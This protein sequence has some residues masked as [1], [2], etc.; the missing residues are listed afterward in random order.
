MLEQ[1]HAEDG[2]PDD[3][4]AARS[5]PIAPL[6][7]ALEDTLVPF[8]AGQV[9]GSYR[10][11]R[12][13][14]VGGMS[15]VYLAERTDLPDQKV[16]LKILRMYSDGLKRRFEQ[17]KRIL[18][19]LDHPHIARFFDMGTTPEGCPWFALEYIDGESISRWCDRRKVGIEAR[20]A[21]FLD[22]CGAVSFAH[23]NLVIHRDLKPMNIMVTQNGTPK[24]LDFGIAA[25]LNPETGDQQKATIHG[26]LMMTPAYASPEQW[27]GELLNAATDVYSLGVVL[28]QMLT[29]ALPFAVDTLTPLE[30]CEMLTSREA[31]Y[32][33]EGFTKP[34]SAK[35]QSAAANR[36]LAVGK[37]RRLLKGDLRIIVAK[38]LRRE[39][40]DRY[41]SVEALADDLRRY[42]AGLPIQARP[43]TMRYRLV[44]YTRRH[45]YLLGFGLSAILIL[46]VSLGVVLHEQRRAERERIRAEEALQA[47]EEVTEYLTNLFEFA[48]PAAHHG[49]EPSAR[50]ML[51]LGRERLSGELVGRDFIRGRLFQVMG[52]VYQSMG[53]DDQA[54]LLLEEAARLFKAAERPAFLASAYAERAEVLA[55]LSKLNE[56]EH[57]AKLAVAV[58]EGADVPP[59]VKA[60]AFDAM[61]SLHLWRSQLA[62]ALQWYQRALDLRQATLTPDDPLLAFSHFNLGSVY[63][64]QSRLEEAEPHFL[65]ALALSRGATGRH[66][67]A[68]L[69]YK[70]GYALLLRDRGRY[71]EALAIGREVVAKQSEIFGADHPRTLLSMSHLG[72]T[73]DAADALF[74]ASALHREVLNQMEEKY[75]KTSLRYGYAALNLARTLGIMGRVEA[76]E[77]LFREVISIMT[78]THGAENRDSMFAKVGLSRILNQAQRSDEAESLAQQTLAYYAAPDTPDTIFTGS[79]YLIMAE[80]QLGLG[81]LDAAVSWAG[82]AAESYERHLGPNADFSLGMRTLYG[83]ALMERGDVAEAKQILLDAAKRQSADRVASGRL[84]QARD[85]AKLELKCGRAQAAVAL[86]EPE[87]PTN[88]ALAVT[89]PSPRL[90]FT[91]TVQ[92]EALL[93]LGRTQAALE[94]QREAVTLALRLVEEGA[95]LT[96]IPLAKLAVIQAACGQAAMAEATLAKAQAID[97]RIAFPGAAYH[98]VVAEA[99]AQVAFYNRNE[100]LAEQRLTKLI[101]DKAARFGE[102]HPYLAEDECLLARVKA[103]RGDAAGAEPLFQKALARWAAL[104]EVVNP[105][106]GIVTL[107]L[108][109]FYLNQGRHDAAAAALQQGLALVGEDVPAD[110]PPRVLAELCAARL[111]SADRGD[112]RQALSVLADNDEGFWA[113]EYR[114]RLVQGAAH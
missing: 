53:A 88:R 23:Q 91:L 12:Q 85:L 99:A 49:S 83:R 75:G 7:E 114:A 26:G 70:E 97:A 87:L 37:L 103:Q 86:I 10:I 21:L 6:E 68:A 69:R 101:A 102:N 1:T 33:A 59:A 98:A 38:A 109:D 92:A 42:L 11:L 62:D 34:A 94:T 107:F 100:A 27:R 22:V 63:H 57:Q 110:A 41:P 82:K 65:Q 81:E 19:R 60:E 28:F 111:N 18:A 77:Q 96:V 50:E 61:G 95:L 15:Y 43:P 52:R 36:Q 30:A 55:G 17:E 9:M 79:S 2:V 5:T 51:D 71:P 29:G 46:S 20:L 39:P 84:L 104:G 113:E 66:L 16:A 45:R 80:A 58:A 47:A 35:A 13:I 8:R 106:R 48:D 56:M 90:V 64:Y 54:D 32:L 72:M 44:K 112:G 24:L 3:D 89:E 74:E 73:A 25:L 76:S 4:Y 40:K 14:G 67:A 108:A 105:R 31:P 78:N 93:A